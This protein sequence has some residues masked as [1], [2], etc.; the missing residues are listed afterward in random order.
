VRQD[1][2]R[3]RPR[4]GAL[5]AS[6]HVLEADATRLVVGFA[7][8]A[9]VDS[10]E[11]VRGDIEAALLA[12]WGNAIRLQV[13]HEPGGHVGALI[14][15]ESMQEAESLATDRH[16]R[17]EEARRHPMIQKVQDLFGVGIREIKT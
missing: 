13:K 15:A 14:R 7:D 17:E 8:R 6:A 1:L 2:E 16:R 12:E 11:R 9:D 10:A 4:I 3:R 5:L